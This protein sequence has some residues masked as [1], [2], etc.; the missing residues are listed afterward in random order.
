MQELRTFGLCFVALVATIGCGSSDDEE[1]HDK[2]GLVLEGTATAEAFDLI[3][4]E[5]AEDWEWAA[6]VPQSPEKSAVL[7]RAEPVKF[8]WT[9]DLIHKGADPATAAPFTG[10]GFWLRYERGGAK[11]LDVFTSNR[12][13]TPNAD[14]W[15]RLSDGSGAITL[16]IDSADFEANAIVTDGGPYTGMATEFTIE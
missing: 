13:Y 11:L 16:H 10:I 1:V 3:S 12:D 7:A 4:T 2:S 6:G 5:E 14:A 15:K 8:T 9:T